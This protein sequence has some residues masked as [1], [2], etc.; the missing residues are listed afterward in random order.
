MKAFEKAD[1]MNYGTAIEITE[2]ENLAIVDC[3]SNF[4]GFI[5]DQ[6]EQTQSE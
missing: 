3:P 1:T 6:D 4:E 5:S 2:Y